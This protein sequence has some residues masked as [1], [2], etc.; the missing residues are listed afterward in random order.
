MFAPRIVTRL[1]LAFLLLSP[2]P[3]A[4]LSWLH[5]QA[6]ERTLQA[7]VLTTLSSIAD[8]KTEQIEAYVG[9]RMADSQMLSRLTVPRAALRKAIK[10]G[11]IVT[12]IIVQNR[13]V[14]LHDLFT[15]MLREADFHDL[16]LVAP[17][18]NVV[19]SMLR[20]SDLGTNLND[21]PYRDTYLA[22]AHRDA[23]ATGR[24]QITRASLYEPS[25]NRPAI[26]FVSPV[27]DNGDLLGTLALQLN[28]DKLTVV[29]HDQT[30]LGKTGETVLAQRQGD[31]ALYVAPLR[32]IES[33]AFRRLVAIADTPPPMRAGLN[34]ERGHGITHDYVGRPVVAA[35]R[36]LP[37]LGW[38]MVVKMDIDEAFAPL[39]AVR[40]YSQ[41]LLLVMLLLAFVVALLFGR[42]LVLPIRR[43]TNA[44]E[45]I[46][47]GNLRERAPTD[48]CDEFHELA[49]SFNRMADRLAEEQAQLEERIHERTRALTES[50]QQLN[51]AQQIAHIGSWHL[52]IRANSLHWSAETF[53]I[54]GVSDDTPLA[55]EDFLARTHP[56]DRAAVDAAWQAALAG[57]PYDIVHRIVVDGALK[58]VRERAELVFTADGTLAGGTGTVQDVTT[59]RE[60]E[61]ALRARVDEQ[62]AIFEAA[63]NGIAFV[64]DRVVVRCNRRL[65]EIFGYAAGEMIGMPTR[66]WYLDEAEYALAGKVYEMLARGEIHRREQRVKR[67]DGS[68]FWMHI[69]GRC[70]Y[71]NDLSQGTVWVIADITESKQALARLKESEELLRS[72]ITT[73]GEGFVIYDP[74]DRLVLCNDKYLD[75]YRLSAPAMRPG[76]RFE[77]IIRYGVERGQYPQAA[78]REEEWIAERLAAHRSEDGEMIQKLDDGRWIR[79]REGRTPSGH[80]VGFRIDVTEIYQSKEAAEAANRA[81]SEFLA[82]MSHEIRTPMNAILGLTQLVLDTPLEARQREFLGKALSSG[83]AL[84][85]ILNDILDYSKIEAGR[86]DIDQTAFSVEKVLREVGDLFSARLAEKGID[87]FFDISPDMPAEVVGDPLR[88]HQVLAN[89]VGNALK[90]TE[91]GTIHIVAESL[92][93]AT[94]R[95]DRLSLRFAVRDTGIGIRPE[96]ARHLFKP[97]TQGDGSITRKYGGTGLGLAICHRLVTL[98]GGEIAASGEAGHGATFTFTIEVTR[99]NQAASHLRL[100]EI[101][102]MKVL[103]VDDQASA[104]DILGRLLAA[105]GVE[106]DTAADGHVALEMIRSARAGKDGYGIILLDWRMPDLDGIEIARRMVAEPAA[107]GSAFKVMMVTAPDRDKLIQAA[108]ELQLDGILTKPVTP[109]MLFDALMGSRVQPAERSSQLRQKSALAGWH[110]GGARVLVAEDNHYNQQVA[111]GFLEK[112]GIVVTLADN[113]SEA[114][115]MAGHA[116]FDAIFMD[117]H[118]PV[119]D[120][121]EATRRIR[122]LPRGNR[123]PIIAMTAAVMEEDRERCHAAGM[124]DFVPK[125]VDPDELIRVLGNY[126]KASAAPLPA[127]ALTEIATAPL[128][129]LPEFDLPAALR[130]VGGD[131]ALLERLLTDFAQTHADFADQLAAHLRQGDLHEAAGKLHTLKGVANN[132]GMTAL[133]ETVRLLESDVR[134]G[135]TPPPDALA[136]KIAEARQAIAALATASPDGHTVVPDAAAI[137]TLIER[138]R[139]YL[140]ERELVPDDA[141]QALAALARTGLPG[142]PFAHLLRQID[143]FDH[144]GAL[145]TLAQIAAQ[146]GIPSD[147]LA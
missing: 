23:I 54:F 120:G 22:A 126:L 15:A 49:E 51:Q 1:V 63:T 94:G 16:L 10:T 133:A 29:T 17:R 38:S 105:W 36:H 122:A 11:E 55:Y 99:S 46:A 12:S 121:L 89:L 97:F 128:P 41:S 74:D 114:L 35:W 4:G 69:S 56:D 47:A 146:F 3:L 139:P 112:L 48:G 34:G 130:R 5:L 32:H 76:A 20:E 116:D 118:M 123:V 136:L 115:A 107:Y 127:A 131:R 140:E 61:M 134:A 95:D 40:A 101:A 42:S 84:L 7:G 26:F 125:P 39:H 50:E 44:T 57:A 37:A 25:G 106:Y 8:K 31:Q 59:Q 81:K 142:A 9:E 13:T 147:Y 67:K 102:G 72:A 19:F 96:L 138:L 53:R 14:D 104:R 58:W 73:I 108:G 113:G 88:L 33:A 71:G 86:L 45:R 132:L 119:M 65:E 43:L 109:S 117:L 78:G 66:A 68:I 143:D 135:K 85:G 90:F 18:G 93:G 141:M 80:I 137:A 145:A 6:F 79:L 129:D 21:G 77:D 92:A 70:I 28:L 103:V 83:R 100:Q 111:A 75:I 30:G 27:I 64:K 52:N 144:D 87:L 98:M 24:D 62:L 2:L 82:N 91:R 60:A 124:D 110:F